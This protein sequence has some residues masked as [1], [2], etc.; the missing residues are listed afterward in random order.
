M[1]EGMNRTELGMSDR[2]F[3][4]ERTLCTIATAESQNILCDIQSG[5]RCNLRYGLPTRTSAVGSCP[6]QSDMSFNQS[7]AWS[8]IC[9]AVYEPPD[10]S[11]RLQ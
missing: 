8:H 10:V 9:G 5:G 11:S 3:C 7:I 4:I 6:G 1:D 2:N